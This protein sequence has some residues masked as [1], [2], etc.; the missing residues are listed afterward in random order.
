MT[1]YHRGVLL[2]NDK[3]KYILT[4]RCLPWKTSFSGFMPPIS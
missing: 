4:K 3:D 1:A 2:K